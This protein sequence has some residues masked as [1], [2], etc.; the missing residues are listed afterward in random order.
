MTRDNSVSSK[1]P[2]VFAIGFL[3]LFSLS[4]CESKKTPTE[5]TQAFWSAM[6][7]NNLKV[8]KRYCSSQ[9]KVLPSSSNTLFKE[10]VFTYGKI[11]IDGNQATVEAKI[12]PPFNKRSSFTTFLIKEND[13][14]K[15]DCQ[16]SSSSL[17]G[18]QLVDDFFK[19]LNEFGKN[20]NNQLEQQ[21]PLIEKEIEKFGQELEK[22]IDRFK[23]ELKKSLPQE[24]QDPYQDSI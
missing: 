5:T 7:K 22:Q 6:A 11:T 17:V 24:Q 8:A 12:T 23:N 1:K 16:R 18:S 14:W 21:L 2:I 19:N 10:S 20:L 4:A 3:F 15:I 9:S 13:I